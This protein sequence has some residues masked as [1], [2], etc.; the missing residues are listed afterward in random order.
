MHLTNTSQEL[1]L[2]PEDPCGTLSQLLPWFSYTHICTCANTDT[3][4]H[5]HITFLPPPPPNRCLLMPEK[6]AK[7]YKPTT[8]S[9]Y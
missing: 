1:K 7:Q 3:H 2:H 5:T 9:S 6:K 8:S 4:S